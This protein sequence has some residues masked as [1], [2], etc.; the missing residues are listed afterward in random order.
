MQ[1]RKLGKT[2]EQLSII[3]LGGILV[4]NIDQSEANLRV[5]S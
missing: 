1:K 2:E 4:S 3:G 5:R